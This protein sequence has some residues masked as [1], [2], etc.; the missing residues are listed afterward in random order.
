MIKIFH[1]IKYCWLEHKD[2]ILNIISTQH[3]VSIFMWML[4]RFISTLIK[5]FILYAPM[6]FIE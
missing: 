1:V 6:K 4:G 5:S 3:N 2:L